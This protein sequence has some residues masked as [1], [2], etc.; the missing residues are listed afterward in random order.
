MDP[1]LAA[2]RRRFQDSFSVTGNI[3][4]TGKSTRSPQRTHLSKS[5]HIRSLE[6]SKRCF[7]FNP[8]LQFYLEIFFAIH[9]ETDMKEHLQFFIHH[10][11][12]CPRQPS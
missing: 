7:L 2:G 3:K 12:E 4:G 5:P 1:W 6:S 9:S 10:D 8:V 11:H